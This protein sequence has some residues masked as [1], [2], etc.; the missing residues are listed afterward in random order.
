MERT[1]YNGNRLEAILWVI[2][3]VGIPIMAEILQITNLLGVANP[4]HSNHRP[5]SEG[6]YTTVF[7]LALLLAPSY[8]FGTAFARL[9]GTSVCV[10]D[11][12]I[13]VIEWYGKRVSHALAPPVRVDHRMRIMWPGLRRTFSIGIIFDT[14]YRLQVGRHEIYIN[15]D[16]ADDPHAEA[17][18]FE[19]H[20]ERILAGV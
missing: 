16:N 12:V 10:H 18:R 8:I 4:L 14:T 13:E 17:Q 15:L 1:V 2:M 9:R 20:L 11:G 5:G 3:L 6:A 19:G 7:A